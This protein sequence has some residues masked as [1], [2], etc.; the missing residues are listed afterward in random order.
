MIKQIH[1]LT[2]N[3]F[4]IAT[5]ELAMKPFDIEILPLRLDVPEI[6][7]ENN[8]EIARHGAITAAQ[9]IG[10]PVMREDH[11]LYL[12][13][14]PG[15][16]GPYMAHTER[17]IPPEDVFQLIN[18]KDRTGYF[19]MAL[20]YAQPDGGVVEYSFRLPITI[21]DSIRPGGKDF[22]W[23]SII[24]ID[25]DPRALSEYPQEDRYPLFTK[26]YEALARGLTK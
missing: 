21:V 10:N 14:F 23:D 3:Q 4:K 25:G 12:N 18:G 19:E 5:A 11:G 26:N 7:A 24:S 6:Q 16:P 13:A 2:Q 9:N 8:V 22:G 17:I 15:W 1:F 20:A